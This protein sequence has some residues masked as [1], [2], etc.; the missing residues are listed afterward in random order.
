MPVPG[1]V[2]NADCSIQAI[3]YHTVLNYFRNLPFS[4]NYEDTILH[5][6]PISFDGEYSITN[7]S[8]EFPSSGANYIKYAGLAQ[9]PGIFS[10]V[11]WIKYGEDNE[12]NNTPVMFGNDLNESQTSFFRFPYAGT[13]R[14]GVQDTLGND[15]T[16]DTTVIDYTSW[17]LV[18]VVFTGTDYHIYLN[19]ILIA[20]VN[21]STPILLTRNLWFGSYYGYN[22]EHTFKGNIR[23]FRIIDSAIS[24]D[25]IQ[26]IYETEA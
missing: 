2:Y 9:Q 8:L 19:G 12:S 15:Y 5:D 14:M 17:T 3:L 25:Q 16:Y 24:A 11:F 1:L 7:G 18:S 21:S 10:I 20:T 6:T 13:F 23:G 22:D 26:A 4:S